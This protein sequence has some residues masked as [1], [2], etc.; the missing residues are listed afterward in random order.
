MDDQNNRIW[1][2]SVDAEHGIYHEETNRALV[3]TSRKC[4]FS[5]PHPHVHWQTSPSHSQHMFIIDPPA[6][7]ASQARAF[8]G[9]LTA[10][11]VP[12]TETLNAL[13]HGRPFTSDGPIRSR[14]EIKPADPRM[15]P[16]RPL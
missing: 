13:A 2:G 7:A 15:R 6:A 9:V 12:T 16:P 1:K 3:N 5:P 8:T 4:L 11:H 14:G 10:T